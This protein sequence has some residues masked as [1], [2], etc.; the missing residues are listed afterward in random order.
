MNTSNLFK[1]RALARVARDQENCPINAHVVRDMREANDRLKK[2]DEKSERF[3][4]LEG[5]CSPK[6]ILIPNINALGALD[7]LQE[8]SQ[9]MSELIDKIRTHVKVA[10]SLDLCEFT[11]IPIVLVGPPGCGKSYIAEQIPHAL[12]LKKYDIAMGT[13]QEGFYL[14]G[15]QRGYVNHTPG[16]I[17]DR[18]S[19]TPI[20]NPFFV[21]DEMEKASWRNHAEGRQGL[22]QSMLQLLERDTSERFTDLSLDV[23]LN[24]S[25]VS[26]IATANS[27]DLIPEPILSRIEVIEVKQPNA[28]QRLGMMED[29]FEAALCDL[30]VDDRWVKLSKHVMKEIPDNV[31][32]RDIRIKA[33]HALLARLAQD[34]SASPI[35]IRASDIRGIFANKFFGQGLGFMGFIDPR[36]QRP[37]KRAAGQMGLP[38]MGGAPGEVSNPP[39]VFPD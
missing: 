3:K 4:T 20:A 2:E 38:G 12:G 29:L 14:T 32:P 24:A 11:T 7:R 36:E 37:K 10:D 28:T 17:A 30:G 27:I 22:E 15:T 18:L 6:K 5:L 8:R 25:R 13:A 19:K 23:Q 1:A 16:R 26:Y 31:S 21:L 34:P 9:N 39:V 33:R 35:L